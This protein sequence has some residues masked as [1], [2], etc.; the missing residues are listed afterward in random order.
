MTVT[1]GS[2]HSKDGASTA[3]AMDAYQETRTNAWLDRKIGLH[4]DK[5]IDDVMAELHIDSVKWR[6]ILANCTKHAVQT[7]KPSSRLLND[8][9]DFNSF[10]KIITV[11][12]LN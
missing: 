9:I 10:I 5:M 2:E 7:I 6:K 8:S 3:R 1:E 4:L 11:E 12:H